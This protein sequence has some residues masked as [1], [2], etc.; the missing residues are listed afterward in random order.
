M[1]LRDAQSLIPQ[2]QPF[3]MINSL[4]KLDE[5][6][7]VCNFRIPADNLFCDTGYFTEPGIIEHIAQT[8]AAG[9]GYKAKQSQRQPP[10]GFIGA[11]KNLIIHSLPK[12]GSTI[13]TRV[14]IEKE[15]FNVTLVNATVNCNTKLIA[16][17]EMKI[18]LDQN[19]E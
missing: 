16:A 19:N 6:Y 4:L 8:A 11:I 7:T 17:C 10:L 9:V 2:Q 18:F 5:K 3:V 1:L 12:I 13:E 14:S 15:I